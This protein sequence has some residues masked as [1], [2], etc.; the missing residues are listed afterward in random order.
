MDICGQH[1]SHLS[2]RVGANFR[3]SVKRAIGYEDDPAVAHNTTINEYVVTWTDDRNSATRST[4]IYAQLVTS[5]GQ[6]QGA[7]FR[8]S[9]GTAPDEAG[10]Q[11]HSEL[12][13]DAPNNR[14]LVVWRDERSAL[15]RGPDIFGQAVR[16]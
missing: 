12:A 16:G 8:I 13:D 2:E 14:Y 9:L 3:V 11:S 1:L 4:D 7:N 10:S 15:T 6:R 5:D